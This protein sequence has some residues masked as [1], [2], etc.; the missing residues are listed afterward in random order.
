VFGLSLYNSIAKSPVPVAT[1]NIS[2]GLWGANSLLTFFLHNISIPP[3]K[4]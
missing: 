3:D 2:L 1:S 4:K